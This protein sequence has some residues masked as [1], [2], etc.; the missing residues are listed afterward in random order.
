[1][2]FISFI[3][4]IILYFQVN[5]DDRLI[6]VMIHFRHGARA[7]QHFLD[8]E[9]YLDF[10]K[11][12]WENPG[13]L[14]G[15]GQRSHYLLGIRNRIK[16]VNEKRFLSKKFDPHEILI[17][18]SPFNRTMLSVAAQLQGLYP[19]NKGLGDNITDNQI[20]VSK[21]QVSVDYEDVE[22]EIKN[23]NRSALP[24]S[25]VLAPVRMINNNEAKITLYDI[26]PCTKKRDEIKT[27]H[28]QTIDTLKNISKEFNENFGEKLNKFYEEKEKKEYDLWFI[29]NFCDALISSYTHKYNMSELKKTEL[30]PEVLV[31]YCFEYV[32]LNF[33]DWINGDKEHVLAHLESSKMMKELIHYMGERITADIKGEDLKKK[34]D[35]YSKP[36]MMMISG[37]DSTVSCYQIFLLN[38]LGLNIIDNYQY[39]KF[40]AQIAFEVTTNKTITE[41]KTE[42]DY[43]ISYYFN[44]ELILNI[45]F[46]EFKNKIKPHIWSDKKINE[47]CGFEKDDDDDDDSNKIFLIVFISTTALFLFT[48]ICLTIRLFKLKNR[49][50]SIY[51]SPLMN[52]SD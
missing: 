22:E 33:R 2:S 28:S 39:P 1:M 42:D 44:D 24:Y 52:K 31:D 21:P 23:L 32:K 48:T 46:P 45:T 5:N 13:E 50:T 37:H 36:K 15:V 16:Y 49:D 4:L 26:P 12:K 14:T 43:L 8:T 40:S 3:Y 17:Y 34:Y 25:M 30:D 35:D 6:F 18:S 19:Q 20:D 9:N 7:P 29:D 41:E 51:D 47:F 10:I 38:A 11:Q 27:K